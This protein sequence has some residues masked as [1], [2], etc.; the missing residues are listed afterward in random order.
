ML[1]V[2]WSGTDEIR[3]F[4]T[5]MSLMSHSYCHTLVLYYCILCEKFNSRNLW[6]IQFYL[7]HSR[8][9]LHF[10][11]WRIESPRMS[12][13]NSSKHLSIDNLVVDKVWKLLWCFGSS[14]KSNFRQHKPQ[15]LYSIRMSREPQWSL[16]WEVQYFLLSS[17][18]GCMC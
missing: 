4:N 14:Y 5:A 18:C 13:Y 17:Y 6:W 9:K 11:E 12:V 10:L 16:L 7:N 2:L 15:L 3:W 1:T 8:S